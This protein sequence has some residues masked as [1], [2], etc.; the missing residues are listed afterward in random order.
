MNGFTEYGKK[1]VRL[2]ELFQDGNT[3]LEVLLQQCLELGLMIAFRVEP[4]P[5]T[6]DNLI[7]DANQTA[8]EACEK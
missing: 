2:G 1:L 3:T 6:A 5:T 7:I 8:P 4:N